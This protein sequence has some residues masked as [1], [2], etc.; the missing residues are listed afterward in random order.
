V[1]FGRRM[2]FAMLV[3]VA[4]L[5]LIGMTIAWLIHMIL[6]A[7]YGAVYFVEEN[8]LILYVE[9][10]ASIVI[11]LFAIVVFVIQCKRLGETRQ[12]ERRF[13]REGQRNDQ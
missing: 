8:P 10:G 1:L 2:G 4:Q 11:V 5:L 9:I 3:L 7:K 12:G 13:A 6:I